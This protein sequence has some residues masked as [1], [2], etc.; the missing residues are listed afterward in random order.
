MT[1]VENLLIIVGLSLDVFA[2]MECQG[3]LVRK[4]DKKHLSLV[5]V[6]I[7]VAHLLAL[8]I[9][10]FLATLLSKY[11]DT[12]EEVF[13]GH[14]LA[15]IILFGLGIRLIIKAIVNEQVNEHLEQHLGFKRFIPLTGL[16]GIYTLVAGF[17][18]GFIGTT[19]WQLLVMLAIALVLF[20]VSGMYCGFRFGFES[21]RRAY[22]IGAILLIVAGCDMVLRLI[23]NTGV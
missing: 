17:A 9:G 21:K 2:A 14:I 23:F 13:I 8:D 10:Y 12:S 16:T 3:S 1:W 22:V 20:V 6:I 19:I 15:V 11:G 18:F 4:V 5:T 7:V